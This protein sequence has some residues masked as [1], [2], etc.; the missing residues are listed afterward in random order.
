MSG[1]TLSTARNAL[2][3]RDVRIK[4][5]CEAPV[6]QMVPLATER[7][8]LSFVK[9]LDDARRQKSSK[10]VAEV[11]R[12]IVQRPGWDRREAITIWTNGSMR[13]SA[14]K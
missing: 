10:W 8:C 2:L 4:L 12:D 7:F 5:D 13:K 1:E 11:P 9:K 3:D 6:T 14:A